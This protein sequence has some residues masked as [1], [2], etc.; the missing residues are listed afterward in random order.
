[1]TVKMRVDNGWEHIGDAGPHAGHHLHA[2]D[3][4][5]V[6]CLECERCLTDAE[7]DIAWPRQ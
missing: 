7:A 1:M 5:D 6:H 4:Q 3:M 2:D